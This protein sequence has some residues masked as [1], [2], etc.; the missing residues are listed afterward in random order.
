MAQRKTTKAVHMILAWVVAAGLLIG[1][2]GCGFQTAIG[3]NPYLLVDKIDSVDHT[4]FFSQTYD[5]FMVAGLGTLDEE[6]LTE[7][8]EEIASEDEDGDGDVTDD[9]DS[10]NT[11]L[12]PTL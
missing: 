6:A 5:A 4:T 2:A 10:D 7:I 8:V 3:I 9:T 1:G 12:F 11:S